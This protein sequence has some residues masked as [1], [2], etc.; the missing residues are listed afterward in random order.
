M[1][2]FLLFATIIIAVVL[3][4]LAISK[5]KMHPFIVMLVIALAVGLFWGAVYPESG[6][7]PTQVVNQVKSGFGSIMT[8]I[9]IVILCGTIIGTILEKTGAALTMANAILK[10]VG[11]KNSVVAMGAMG[12][13]TGIPVFCDSGFVVLSP[14]SRALAQQS[15]VSLAVMGTALSGG[16]YATHCLVPPTP[17]P[18]AMAGTLE[19]DLGLT[20]LV[21][22]II[23]IPAV[24]VAIIYAKKVASK[25][26]I[27]ANSEYTLEELQVKYG[28]LPGTLQSFAPILLPIILIGLA[29]I[30]DFPSKPFGEGGIYQFIMFIGNPVV[31][32][33]LGVFL[34]MTLIPK[35]EKG[36]TL[37]WVTEGVTSSAGILA[38]TCAGSSFGAIL[39]CL[40]I[41]DSVGGLV[42]SGLG[43][44]VP[45]VIAMI[46]KLA[47]G[48]STVAMITTAGMMAPLMEAMGFTSPLGRVLVVLAIGAGS[49]VASHAN[50]SYF[51]VV[52]QFSDMKT[53]E[54]YKCQ[55][56]MT[57]VMGITVVLILFVISL[58]L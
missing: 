45:F 7:T 4:V 35:E 1:Q 22:L 48:A 20:I 26:N 41:A 32:L 24:I 14:I 56:G 34:S 15:N 16:L 53:E 38:I 11:Q 21:G 42:N 55:T 12:Y 49:M 46:L 57:A 3:M 33:L 31:A 18:I 58:F 44:L 5:L 47:M 23:S 51:W 37:A 43:V 25:V 29:S 50:D 28:K 30:T 6:L 39:K 8:S 17:G 27:P 36:N 10:L 40:P 9:G 52:S 19:A 2:T 13:V 54:A